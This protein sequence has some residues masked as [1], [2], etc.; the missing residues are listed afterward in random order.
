MAVRELILAPDAHTWVALARE[1]A[2]AREA[3]QARRERAGRF[4]AELGLPVD[5]LLVMSGHQASFWHAGILAKRLTLGTFAGQFNAAAAWCIVD[6]DTEDF[7]TLRAP[8]RSATGGWEVGQLNLAPESTRM[9]IAADVPAS[10]LP[11]FDVVPTPI[12]K[13]ATPGVAAGLD[14]IIAAVQTAAHRNS[15][16]PATVAPDPL[17]STS[18]S[19][20]DQIEAATSILLTQRGLIGDQASVTIFLATRIGRTALFRAVLDHF[21]TDPHAA[22]ERYNAAL[23]AAPDARL[24]PLRIGASAAQIELPIWRIERGA[25]R[26]RVYADQLARCRAEGANLVP[27]A[28][29]M[30]G[31]LRA[32]GCDLFIHGLGGAGHATEQGQGGYDRATGAWLTPLLGPLAPT[33]LATATVTLDLGIEGDVGASVDGSADD[34]ASIDRAVWKAHAAEHSPALLGDELAGVRKAALVAT[35]KR[36]RD[37]LARRA[38][39]RQVHDLLSRVRAANA[40]ELGALHDRAAALA[41]RKEEFALARDRTFGWPLHSDDDLRA[42]ARQIAREFQV[43]P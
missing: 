10:A 6:Q 20:A 19:A 7:S 34:A 38:L 25:P 31:L 41:A 29:L 42:L 33:V 13:A 5:G 35:L 12:Q 43:R 4:R 24:T 30:T 14:Q 16:A 23:A 39:Y 8:V 36:E 9:Q 40:T 1:Y 21:E 22:A 15:S 28:L 32:A 37:P 18:R 26:K 3:D 2:A 17:T 27:R 11:A